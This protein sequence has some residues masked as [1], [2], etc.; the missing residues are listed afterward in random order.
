MGKGQATKKPEERRTEKRK[1]KE[2]YRQ[3]HK[4]AVYARCERR[5]AIAYGCG[6]TRCLQILPVDH[7]HRCGAKLP[8]VRS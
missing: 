7:T 5:M 1:R 3:V 4:Q 2:V 8:G 6:C